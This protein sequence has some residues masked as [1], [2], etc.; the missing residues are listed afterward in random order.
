MNE[1]DK[2]MAHAEPMV[3][4]YLLIRRAI[5]ALGLLLPLALGPIGYFVFGI[6]IQENMSSYYHTPLRDVFVGTLCVIGVF[7]ICYRGYD[8]VE[9]WSANAG[10]VAA[11]GVA[12]FPLDAHSN[13]LF[14]KSLIGY[15]HTLSGGVFFLTLAIYSLYHFPR[16]SRIEK[17]PHLRERSFIFRISGAV[18]LLCMT[19]MAAYLFL[20]SPSLKETLNRF[21]L[22]FWLEWIAVW[23]FASAWL[24]K[25]RV[26]V[27]D[28]AVEVLAF[29][30]HFL[31]NKSER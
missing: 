28:I 16:N 20:P 21:N 8:W 3:L 10:G 11:L 31:L 22:L 1:I 17:E 2:L 5:G 26:L 30:S 6:D 24:A 9:N 14:Q 7:L 13:P 12:L 19:A 29:A 18:I 15:L 4:S 23:A 25:G 27:A